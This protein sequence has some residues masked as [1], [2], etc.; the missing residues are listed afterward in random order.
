MRDG[1]DLAGVI[2]LEVFG[3]V[4]LLRSLA[5]PL[6]CRGRGIAS[7]LAHKAEEH[8]RSRGVEAVYLLT[9]TAEGFF[10]RRSYDRVDRDAVPGAIKATVEFQSLCPASAVCMVRHLGAG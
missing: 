9:T 10:A 7:R 4:A 3:P 2:G 8:A 1:A 6:P 5:V